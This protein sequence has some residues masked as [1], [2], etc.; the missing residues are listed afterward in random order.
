[1]TARYGSG[2]GRGA[3]GLA[4]WHVHRMVRLDLAESSAVTALASFLVTS[5]DAIIAEFEDRIARLA[6][7]PMSRSA[8][9]DHLPDFFDEL[10]RALGHGV[11]GGVGGGNVGPVAG[12]VG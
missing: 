1:M 12:G 2:P 6:P 8:L 10:R 4:R 9:R 5:R 11:A 3:L 7:E